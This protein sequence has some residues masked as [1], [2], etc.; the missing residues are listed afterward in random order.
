VTSERNGKNR[1]RTLGQ[2]KKGGIKKGK[3]T[4]EGKKNKN[5]KPTQVGQG[6]IQM[7]GLK[8]GK[9]GGL[10]GGVLDHSC[11]PSG[12]IYLLTLRRH[13]L[14]IYLFLSPNPS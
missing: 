12:F 1:T 10:L 7:V 4:R 9:F 5:Q 3:G 11:P 2:Q 13:T 8:R 6:F 14:F